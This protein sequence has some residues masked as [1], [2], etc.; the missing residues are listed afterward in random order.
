MVFVSVDKEAEG[1]KGTTVGGTTAG[2]TVVATFGLVKG[3]NYGGIEAEGGFNV[4]LSGLAEVDREDGA[5]IDD[6]ATEVSGIEAKGLDLLHRPLEKVRP[7]LLVQCHG[8]RN[9]LHA[10]HTTLIC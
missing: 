5:S 10:S 1:T 4:K 3:A 7:S 8:P 9:R 6:D 2:A